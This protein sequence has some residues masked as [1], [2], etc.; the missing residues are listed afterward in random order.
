MLR[1]FARSL[2]AAVLTIAF[3]SEMAA[4]AQEAKKTPAPK[5]EPDE[6]EV[7]FR[8]GS[9]VRMAV[10]TEKLDIVTSYGTL[11]V[12]I[13][14][15]ATIEFGL[16]Y[17]EGAQAKIEAAVA[18]LG[19]ADF[20]ERD[21]ATKTLVDFGPL[22]YPAVHA[23]RNSS[24][25][26][27]ATRAKEIVRRLQ[28]NHPKKDLRTSTDDKIV[29]PKFTIVGNIATA[30]LSATTEL[31]GQVELALVKMQSFR[32]LGG[33]GRPR[34]VTV[35]VDAAKY[36]NAGQWFESGI[37]SDGTTKVQIS[38]KGSVDT[39]PQQPGQW[40][41]GPAGQGAAQANGNLMV[42]RANG[43]V[44]AKG[45]IVPQVHGGALFGRIGEDGE[46]FLIGSQ[47]EGV[48]EREGKLYLH[49]APSPWGC[50]STGSYEVTITRTN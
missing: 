29:T 35:T 11:S 47:H 10:L 19:H 45:Q 5:V 17:P 14:D 34:E 40:M 32:A 28:T 41:V 15:V 33:R 38:A 46:P 26:D 8:D 22:A 27:V 9:V 44:A 49:I 16:H 50:N 37:E 13:Q 36:A 39:W 7:R 25:L 3:A 43:I 1:T 6:V 23:A 20:R 18:K 31:F 12:P 4:L 48:L 2:L 30:K 21:K 24:D 42:L